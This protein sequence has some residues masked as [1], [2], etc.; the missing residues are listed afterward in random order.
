MR[1]ELPVARFR[2]CCRT[3]SLPDL[4]SA[5][6]QGP[7][8]FTVTSS[9]WMAPTMVKSPLASVTALPWALVTSTSGMAS[10]TS[11]L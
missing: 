7:S 8:Y 11:P 10:L 4:L 1:R 3:K 9:G 5:S 2:V 6:C